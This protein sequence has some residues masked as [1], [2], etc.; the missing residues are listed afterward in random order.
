MHDEYYIWLTNLV[1]D[2]SSIRK[3]SRLLETLY[4]T[5][6]TY[7]IL[8]DVNRIKDGIDLRKDYLREMELLT[9]PEYL[10]QKPCSV[11]EMMVALANRIEIDIMSDPDIGNRA[12]EWFWKM[13][14]SME[15][16]DMTNDNFNDDYVDFIL[17]RFLNREYDANGRGGLFTIKSRN[18]DMRRIEIWYQMQ[19]YLDEI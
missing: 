19:Y 5:E 11:L 1:C 9:W 18:V 14:D 4:S 15:L 2:N 3:Y 16:L 13:I 10:E 12:S 17:S 8:L 7:K 6:F